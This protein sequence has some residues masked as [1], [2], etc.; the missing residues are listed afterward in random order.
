MLYLC[1]LAIVAVYLACPVVSVAHAVR[2]GA[3]DRRSAPGRR[4]RRAMAGGVA[5][6]TL[7]CVGYAVAAG[8]RPRVGQV[9]LTSYLTTS[10][11]LLLGHVDRGLSVA[12]TR[13]FRPR[14]GRPP[15]HQWQ[16]RALGEAFLRV[17]LVAGVGLPYVG[18]VVLTYRP[19]TSPV[20]NPSMYRWA[21]QPVTFPATDGTRI[22]GWWIPA[23]GGASDRTL[24]LCPAEAGGPAAALP[25]AAALRLDGYNVLTFDFRGHGD[26]GGQLVS[27]GDLERRDVLGAVRWLQQAH[28]AAAHHVD[29]LGVSTGAAALLAAAAD[30]SPLGQSIDAVAVYAPYGSLDGLDLLDVVASPAARPWLTPPLRWLAAHVALPMADL[31]VGADLSAFSPAAAAANL[32][33]RPLLVVHGMD[34]EVVPFA[35]GQAVYDAASEP[36]Q[37]LWIGDC[38]HADAIRSGA[39]MRA[40]RKYFDTARRLI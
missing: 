13:L 23:P 2:A 6:G 21:Y 27:F 4:V 20:V 40:V 36:K 24:V 11:I 8:G 16:A 3:R 22:A 29:G 19:K 10:L 28:P 26:S 18:A 14:P 38:G 31:Q 25:L 34:D 9:L 12:T 5:L 37:S 7:A 30:P 32:W 39:A 15:G 33:P 35:Q 1:H 17:G